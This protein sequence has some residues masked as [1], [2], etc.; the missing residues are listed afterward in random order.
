MSSSLPSLTEGR[1]T[2][3]TYER[4]QYTAGILY[5]KEDKA[6]GVT[7]DR[8][9]V[10][11]AYYHNQNDAFFDN[12]SLI[13]TPTQ[14]NNIDDDGYLLSSTSGESKTSYEYCPDSHLIQK[15][16][17][18]S[19]TTH[20]FIY[21]DITNN[22]ISETNANLSNTYTYNSSG[23]VTKKTTQK[24]NSAIF[25]EA[26]NDYGSTQN[27][28]LT[29][30]DINGIRT[31]FTYGSSHLLLSSRIGDENV[32]H[33]TQ[34]YDPY[35]SNGRMYQTYLSGLTSITYGYSNGLVKY[36]TRKSYD[37]V[38]STNN[39][40][41][42]RYIL[43]HDN[44]GNSTYVGVTGKNNASSD[45]PQ[46]KKLVTYEY[47]SSVNNGRLQQK[48]YPNGNTV[49]YSYDLFDRL[50]TE[51]YTNNS[52]TNP[53]N[54]Q[55][56]YYY[57]A[58]GRIAR[59]ESVNSNGA[60]TESY[61]YDYD[62]LGRLIHSKELGP[63]KSMILRTERQYDT[64]N[65]LSKY[66]WYLKDGATYTQGFT[67]STGASGDETL[68]SITS[69]FS[70]AGYSWE[71]SITFKYTDL[72]QIRKKTTGHL[73]YRAFSYK[74]DSSTQQTG[75]QVEYMNYRR[76]VSDSNQT[77]QLIKGY[78]FNYDDL[79]NITEVYKSSESGTLTQLQNYTYDKLGQ[80]TGCVD[81]QD[82]NTTRT[83]CYAYDTAGNIT[84]MTGGTGGTKT[85]KYEDSMW[86][87]RLTSVKIGSGQEVDIIYETPSS[88][89]ISG[90]P[91]SYYNGQQYSFSWK[92]GR[93]LATAS[94]GST[95]V[96]YDYDMAGVRSKKTVGST[97]YSYDTI[98]GLV[99]HQKWGN[100]DLYF[101]YDDNNQPYALFYKNSSGTV[102]RYYYLLNLQGDVVA[103]MNGSYS[104]VAEYRYDPW[105]A[106]KVYDANGTEI[107]DTDRI[108][109][110]NPL[111]YRG[112]YYDTDTG[113][114]YLQ[115]RYYDPA[116]GRFINADSYASTGQD[117][118]GN[119]MFTYCK[120]NP[121]NCFD[122]TGCCY[123]SADGH[124]CH[125]AWENLGGQTRSFFH[126]SI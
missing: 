50:T 7:I 82:P 121:T 93:Q 113:L 120:N 94:V 10:Y 11:Y 92:N 49:D 22:L 8:I 5:P 44:F 124:W 75:S 126:V 17:S 14:L 21:Q 105:G 56:K 37:E 90:N 23:E 31:H 71:P 80:L 48:K 91:I 66:N 33:P 32:D 60:V 67:Y 101:V 58:E 28:L 116:I 46:S 53:E 39:P 30:Y 4:W 6:A 38:G 122:I 88:G 76:W 107:T 1:D 110:M 111:R 55:H 57:D 52:S 102:S 63:G 26:T 19:G 62:T 97:E 3:P 45:Y 54:K 9:K 29:S 20:S 2:S 114:Y 16:T 104:L 123:Y 106:V 41:W 89:F 65:R 83:Y 125:D 74:T 13:Q 27:H 86:H 34:Y 100:R 36:L 78:K 12:I 24:Q 103:L 18:P 115:S 25:Y 95:S 84:S 77:G 47:E 96:T 61:I 112:Y 69:K 108:G 118:I 68:T 15:I 73:F 99:T 40:N 109:V 79:G 85:L 87:D 70:L 42:Q 72:Q 59:E 43:A 117:F 64:S 51:S 35:V 98:N 119:N 81:H